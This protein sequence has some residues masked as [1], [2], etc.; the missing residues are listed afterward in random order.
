MYESAGV[1]VCIGVSVCRFL[2]YHPGTHARICRG[3]EQDTESRIL[4]CGFWILDSGL[5]VATHELSQR[6]V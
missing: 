3:I 2:V 5:G 1:L 6:Y 4:D